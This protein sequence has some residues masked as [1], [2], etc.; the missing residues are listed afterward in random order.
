MLLLFLL[1]LS[2]KTAQMIANSAN[3]ISILGSM[4]YLHYHGINLG[5]G[6]FF[7]WTI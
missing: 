4:C 3:V 5:G 2:Y 7:N 1:Q 6:C